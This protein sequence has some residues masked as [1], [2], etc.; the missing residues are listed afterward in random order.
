VNEVLRFWPLLSALVVLLF[1][2]V[3]LQF[4]AARS[5]DDLT[6]AF[7]AISSLRTELRTM[8]GEL[9]YLQGRVDTTE[10]RV[11]THG[12]KDGQTAPKGYVEMLAEVLTRA[13]KV[14]ADLEKKTL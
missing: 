7:A 2:Y 9:S 13:E 12:L 1:G 8:G 3:W 10:H 14:V 5:R 6:N 4:S 11:D